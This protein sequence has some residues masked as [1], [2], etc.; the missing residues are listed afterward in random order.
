M[1]IV[2]AGGNAIGGTKPGDG[3][4]IVFNGGSGVAVVY[5]GTFGAGSR[6]RRNG[7]GGNGRLGIDLGN[8]SVTP[9]DAGD[10]DT[11]AN[12]L[13]NFPVLTGAV[14]TGSTTGIAGTLD[15]RPNITYT[16][17]LFSGATCDASGYGEE[18]RISAPAP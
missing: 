17:E 8:D 2:A 13:Q 3:N 15:S 1:H 5:T 14:S 9:N 10:G 7:I 12:D 6:V 18:L 11:G 4:T 16:V